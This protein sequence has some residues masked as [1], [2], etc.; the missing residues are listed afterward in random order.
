MLVLVLR[1][2]GG[3]KICEKRILMYIWL[4]ALVSVNIYIAC[5]A[6]YVSI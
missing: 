1:S 3:D 5:F 2:L 4:K 6:C